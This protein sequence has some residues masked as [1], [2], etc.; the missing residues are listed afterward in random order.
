MGDT[1]FASAERLT[2][3]AVMCQYNKFC[4]SPVLNSFLSKIDQYIVV[5]NKNRQV[6]YA[7]L[8]F[9]KDFDQNII[10]DVLGKRVGEIIDCRFA[11]CMNGCG[12]SSFCEECGAVQSMLECLDGFDNVQE[13]VILTRNSKSIELAVSSKNIEI[14]GED[15]IL[16][17]ITDLSDRKHMQALEEIFYHDVTNLASTMHSMIQ[18]LHDNRITEKNKIHSQLTRTSEELLSEL[19]SHKI[20]KSAEKKDL[21]VDIGVYNSISI[22]ERAVGFVERLQVARGNILYI[23]HNSADFEIET[24]LHLINR[25]LVNMLSNALEASR[26]GEKVTIGCEID[27]GEKVFWVHN[28]AYIQPVVQAKIFRTIFSTKKRGSGYGT[29]SIRIITESYLGGRA[30]F[31]SSVSFGTIFKIHLK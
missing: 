25:V 23:Y 1:Q 5:L 28:P 16:F 3:D 29:N 27:D 13:C 17:S 11:W 4:S 22:I 2:D 19:T 10:E 18:L 9:L 30:S 31:K 26:F 7:N 12:T 21:T 15:F 6:V 8:S 24:D 14:D 20:L